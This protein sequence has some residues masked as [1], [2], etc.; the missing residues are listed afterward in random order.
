M[1]C[2]CGRRSSSP[3]RP[4]LRPSI[5]PRAIQGGAAAGIGPVAIRAI[6][7]QQNVSLLET[8]RM[9]EQRQALEKAR[10]DAIRKRLNK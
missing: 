1:G 9:D 8:R 5:G 3:V 6:G 10:R 7:M 2:G 4:T